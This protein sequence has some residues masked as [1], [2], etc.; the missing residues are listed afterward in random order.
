MR[1]AA[2][3]T[4]AGRPPL[5]RAHT[6]R[7]PPQPGAAPA[8]V[9][10]P[11]RAGWSQAPLPELLPACPRVCRRA[12][13][14]V[15]SN[16]SLV[17]NPSVS[18]FSSSALTPHSAQ[19]PAFSSCFSLAPCSAPPSG[20]GQFFPSQCSPGMTVLASPASSSR[21]AAGTVGL[22][23]RG[24]LLL[25]GQRVSVLSGCHPCSRWHPL[26]TLSSLRGEGAEAAGRV[27]RAI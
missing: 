23:V 13:A 17:T 22:L 4:Q 7:V 5:G 27:G 1:E 14:A 9:R 16:P 25:Q 21:G 8:P 11:A 10:R 6:R 3:R 15:A 19:L 18:C 20:P 24:V 26:G 12:D 2:Q